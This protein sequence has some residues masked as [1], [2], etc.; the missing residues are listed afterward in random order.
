MRPLHRLCCSL[1]AASIAIL[2]TPWALD[3]A[4]I[5]APRGGAVRALIVGI[6]DYVSAPKLF[7]AVADAQDLHDALARAGVPKDRLHLLL[8]HAATRPHVLDEMR[9]LAANARPGDLVILGFAGHGT[10]VTEMYPGSKP[11]D[12]KDEAYVL[13]QFTQNLK[14]A[15]HDFI[16]GPEIKH[17]IEEL[18]AKG[19]DILFIA[20]T[21]YGGGLT[22]AS[23][24]APTSSEVTGRLTSARMYR[25]K[26]TPTLRAPMPPARRPRLCT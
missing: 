8:D 10:K 13:V 21:C 18:D 20:D 4:T 6:N 26:R 7:G 16:A 17:W 1:A 2:C 14:E 24:Y 23:R 19:V 11:D 22:R 9:A 12:G 15:E 5:S 3:A 25:L